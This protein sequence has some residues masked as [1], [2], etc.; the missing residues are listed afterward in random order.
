AIAESFLHVEV[1]RQSEPRLLEELRADLVRVL[2]DV[3]AAVEDW[4][5][6]RERVTEIVAELDER[7]PPVDPE[8]AGEAKA[9]LEWMGDDHFTFLGFR[10]YELVTE[11]GEDVLRS[12]PGSGLGILRDKGDRPVS[13][14]FAELP[15]EVRRRARAKNVLN[16]TKANSRATVH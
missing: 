14:S 4:R 16:L 6:M 2:G 13:H 7:P 15:A 9:L 10:E 12:I 1:D 11:K 5:A 8:E 3:R